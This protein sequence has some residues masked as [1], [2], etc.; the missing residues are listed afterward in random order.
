MS[1]QHCSLVSGWP[2]RYSQ[3]SPRLDLSQLEENVS[4]LPGAGIN[5][6]VIQVR[7]EDVSAVLLGY[8]AVVSTSD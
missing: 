3:R 6:A 8:Q 1:T 7:S 2:P 5:P 4:F